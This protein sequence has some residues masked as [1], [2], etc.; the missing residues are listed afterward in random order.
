MCITNYFCRSKMTCST[1]TVRN[2][3]LIKTNRELINMIPRICNCSDY[4]IFDPNC[5]YS[6]LLSP[7]NLESGLVV[8]K[9]HCGYS[10]W[11]RD[12]EHFQ[13][14]HINRN[15]HIGFGITTRWNCPFCVRHCVDVMCKRVFIERTASE[16]VSL[17]V[18]LHRVLTTVGDRERER[19]RPARKNKRRRRS[20]K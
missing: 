8:P 11:Q 18:T 13:R 20:V 5:S 12:V 1:K 16:I 6:S 9:R 7:S 2:S 4:P 17:S 15:H 3:A 14:D 19:E 10:V